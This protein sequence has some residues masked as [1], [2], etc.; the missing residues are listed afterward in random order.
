MIRAFLRIKQNDFPEIAQTLE[1]RVSDAMNTGIANYA[2]ASS[3]VIPRDTG[4]MAANTDLD[5]ATPGKLE[6]AF[7]YNQ[8]Y[9]PYVH[10]GTVH[11]RA[12]PWAR[13]TA[14]AMAAEYSAEI[15]R[16]IEG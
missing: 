13:I 12:Q 6:G 10:D 14:T 4:Q 5:P 8:E 2:D 11:Q 7:G 1:E 3:Q 9:S 15:S 16:A